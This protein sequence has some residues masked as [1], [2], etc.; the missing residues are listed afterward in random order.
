MPSG[1]MALGHLQ[2]RTGADG[3]VPLGAFVHPPVPRRVRFRAR[4][5]S[6]YARPAAYAAC[7]ATVMPP[8]AAMS[9]LKPGPI[10]D[11]TVAF[12]M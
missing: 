12:L 10:V 9:S 11:E 1:R 6:R 5:G 2:S 7:C 8:N 4:G 3:F